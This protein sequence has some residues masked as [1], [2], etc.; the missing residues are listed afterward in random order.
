M[1]GLLHHRT[2]IDRLLDRGTLTGGLFYHGGRIG[3]LLDL[4]MLDDSVLID[5]L[6]DH[7]ALTNGLFAHGLL[8][9]AFGR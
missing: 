9:G 7:G 1:G 2:L 6:P 4:P 8:T 3:G 5:R